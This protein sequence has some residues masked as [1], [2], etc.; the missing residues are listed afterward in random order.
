MKDLELTLFDPSNID[1]Y[2]GLYIKDFEHDDAT[3]EL[4]LILDDDTRVELG[5]LLPRAPR[6]LTSIQVISKDLILG[7]QDGYSINAGRIAPQ[8][9][10]V[11]ESGTGT[12]ILTSSGKLKPLVGAGSVS[13]T[14]TSDAITMDTVPAEAVTSGLGTD[15]Y[16]KDY[17][18][19]DNRQTVTGGNVSYTVDSNGNVPFT[20]LFNYANGDVQSEILS[21][22]ILRVRADQWTWCN[23]KVLLPNSIGTINLTW[24]ARPEWSLSV[25]TDEWNSPRYVEHNVMIRNGNLIESFFLKMTKEGSTGN[26]AVTVPIVG[27]ADGEEVIVAEAN[28]TPMAD[29][30][31]SDNYV[32][33]IHAPQEFQ[34]LV[35]QVDY[36]MSLPVLQELFAAYEADGWSELVKSP[37]GVYFI[38]SNSQTVLRVTPEGTLE[39]YNIGMSLSDYSLFTVNGTM[40][41]A[42]KQTTYEDAQVRYI[43]LATGST[44]VRQSGFSLSRYFTQGWTDWITG[45]WFLVHPET[46]RFLT[47][48]LSTLTWDAD[49][50][51]WPGQEPTAL[52]YGTTNLVNS[53]YGPAMAKY[54]TTENTDGWHSNSNVTDEPQVLHYKSQEGAITGYGIELVA[55]NYENYMFTPLDFE[56]VGRNSDSEEWTTLKRFYAP[57][58]G[59]AL[60][61]GIFMLDA[62]K[63]YVQWGVRVYDVSPTVQTPADKRCYINVFQVLVTNTWTSVGEALSMQGAKLLGGNTQM[64]WHAH[65]GTFKVDTSTK[66]VEHLIDDGLRW[67][68]ND[69]L[70]SAGDT[71]IA[72][73]ELGPK[74][75]PLGL[76]GFSAGDWSVNSNV[77]FNSNYYPWRAFRREA[78]NP[79]ENCWLSSFILPSDE[80][81]TIKAVNSIAPMTIDRYA[82][83]G[84]GDASNAALRRSPRDFTVEARDYDTQEW[85]VI[86]RVIGNLFSSADTHYVR[87]LNDREFMLEENLLIDRNTTVSANPVGASTNGVDKIKSR[88]IDTVD[89]AYMASASGTVTILI[90]SE[91]PSLLGTYNICNSNTGAPTDWIL[92]G[93]NDGTSW[94]TL[95]TVSGRTETANG[96]YSTYELTL[97]QTYSKYR[98]VITGHTSTACKVG[99]LG[100]HPKRIFT[101]DEAKVRPY[102]Q[103]QLRTHLTT[104]GNKAVAIGELIFGEE[105]HTEEFSVKLLKGDDSVTLVDSS[106][107]ADIRSKTQWPFRDNHLFYPAQVISIDPANGSV[108]TPLEIDTSTALDKV[109]MDDRLYVLETNNIQGGVPFYQL[110][111]GT[112]DGIWDAGVWYDPADFAAEIGYLR[113]VRSSDGY[114]VGVPNRELRVSSY[115]EDT[116]LYNLTALP[117]ELTQSGN[118]LFHCG[119]ADTEGNV[120]F[121]PYGADQIVK[122]SAGGSLGLVASGDDYFVNPAE[123]NWNQ[124]LHYTI[125]HGPQDT[126][127]NRPQALLSHSD[128]AGN[129]TG[130]RTKVNP[131]LEDSRFVIDLF[132]PRRVTAWES[133]SSNNGLISKY[134]V[135]GSN[136][137]VTYFTLMEVEIPSEYVSS[138]AVTP[139]VYLESPVTYRYFR[140][141]GLE[142]PGTKYHFARFRLFTDESGIASEGGTATV[143]ETTG[144]DLSGN[145]SYEACAWTSDGK[146]AMAPAN[147]RHIA[148]FDPVALTVTEVESE[149]VIDGN[150]K[151]Y[152]CFTDLQ[153]RTHFLTGSNEGSKGVYLEGGIVKESVS[154]PSQLEG[155]AV[156]MNSGIWLIVPTKLNKLWTYDPYRNRYLEAPVADR[157]ATYPSVD[158]E[159]DAVVAAPDGWVYLIPLNSSN[160]YRYNPLTYYLEVT[161]H[162]FED[163][164]AGNWTDGKLLANGDVLLCPRTGGE[165]APGYKLLDFD[166]DEDFSSWL[167]TI[168]SK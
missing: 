85:T 56:I 59:A 2:L 130:W 16:R 93:S 29:S 26:L 65:S 155:R 146:I 40:L 76:S 118:E 18:R 21:G 84:Q 137:G 151:Y 120:Y 154:Q 134:M 92:E 32:A 129:T 62:P 57:E 127:N 33:Q 30:E 74:A 19:A 98:L 94:D 101:G 152:D 153:G 39:K 54:F 4:T 87:T 140:V 133:Q 3:G 116:G 60:R 112:P 128:A 71:V 43:N 11:G 111:D 36:N 96:I 49:F 95:H 70:T 150:S 163:F 73:G 99:Y 89:D 31:A 91:S 158:M 9:N 6:D 103:Y 53:A 44:G 161:D 138:Y 69:G 147:A 80:G 15:I 114:V 102:K 37:T 90:E 164:S 61:S 86:D 13:F 105:G 55:R 68:E 35:G 7:F 110:P 25:N 115:K 81:A 135:E 162:A 47:F 46:S 145:A 132:E 125:I 5:T 75:T 121:I 159:F 143:V 168:Y 79:K 165:G 113:Y 52:A 149:H 106:S 156:L 24:N 14:E 97:S 144:L 78:G 22:N 63:S 51:E 107:N 82:I 109:V 23:F 27:Y 108:S 166:T 122:W 45:T 34:D 72:V 131:S 139:R 48:K 64:I 124:P 88:T 77:I 67:K 8:V 100:L 66:T 136:D 20:A 126:N 1:G 141:T 42:F 83:L 17:C 12:G 28:F 160:I 117:G 50:L 10:T 41:Y 148:L 38:P 58:L 119:I 104:N 142:K 167:N 123:V 157:T